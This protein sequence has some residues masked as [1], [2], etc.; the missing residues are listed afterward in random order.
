ELIHAALDTMAAQPV[1]GAG[2]NYAEASAAVVTGRK[3]IQSLEADLVDL[4]EQLENQKAEKLAYMREVVA[5][6]QEAVSQAKAV[7]D[8][9]RADY[10]GI[11]SDYQS[12]IADYNENTGLANQAYQDFLEARLRYQTAQELYDYASGGY[13]LENTDPHTLYQDRLAEYEDARRLLAMMQAMQA[14]TESGDFTENLDAEYL[15]QREELQQ[16][17]EQVSY[18][19]DAESTMR[20]NL[21]QTNQLMNEG[22]AGTLENAREIFKFGRG[23]A[24]F[25][26]APDHE[27]SFEDFTDF[28]AVENS[29]I[30][31]AVEEYFS[32][33]ASQV[34]CKYSRDLVLWLQAVNEGGGIT[35]TLRKFGLAYFYEFCTSKE[36]GKPVVPV[37][38]MNSQAYKALVDDYVHFYR[39]VTIQHPYYGSQT[40]RVPI[41]VREDW[42]RGKAAS[43]YESVTGGSEKNR[44]LYA[45]FKA[46][47]KTDQM[48]SRVLDAVDNELSYILSDY[49][50]DKAHSKQR[51]YSKWYRPFKWDDADRIGDLR[52]SLPSYSTQ[53]KASRSALQ[54]GIGG[55]G[56]SFDQYV[57]KKTYLDLLLGNREGRLAEAENLITLVQSECGRT[58]SE[59][60]QGHI[61]E[62]FG[63]L[64]ETERE[65]NFSALTAINARL[66]AEIG[67]ISS[68]ITDQ[69]EALRNG[70][71][72]L[73]AR[74]TE[75]TN[76]EEKDWDEIAALARQ[77]YVETDFTEEDYHAAELSY[78]RET[79]SYNAS[80]KA[81]VLNAYGR[82]LAGYYQHRLSLAKELQMEK[83]YS[84]AE[85]LHR[86]RAL[87]EEQMGELFAT[88]MR[89]WT[90]GIKR[91]VGMRKRWRDKFE[92]EYEKKSELWQGKYEHLT[93]LKKVWVDK[94][95][96]SA[97]EAGTLAG[98][99]QLGLDADA[100][101]GEA[102]SLL[103]PDISIGTPNLSEITGEVINGQL[104]SGL[105]GRARG[106]SGR[107]G[108]ETVLVAA[109]LPQMRGRR[110]SLRELENFA[111]EVTAEV[112]EHVAV[113]QAYQVRETVERAEERIDERIDDAN[114]NVEYSVNRTLVGAGFRRNGGQ[115][116][117]KAIVD[118]TAWATET[119]TQRL[120]AYRYFEAPAFDYGVDLSGRTITHTDAEVLEKRV[121]KAKENLEAYLA[122]IFGT[123][124]QEGRSEDL[125]E[126]FMAIV[127]RAEAE[128]AAGARAAE[129]RDE[130]SGATYGEIKGLFNIH[131]GYVPAMDEE[132]PEKVS[133]AGYGEMGR[134]YE[135]FFIYEARFARGI[136]I[137]GQPWYNQKLWDDDADND[138]ES[139]G[140]LGAPTPRTVADVGMA[141]TANLVAPGSGVLLSAALTAGMNL[142]DDAL[143][144]ALDVAG[145]MDAGEA[146]GG[147]AKQ[148]VISMGT[149]FTG[150]VFNGFG[151]GAD[152]LSEGIGGMDF[153]QD[154]LI[155]STA[156][157]A[158]ELTGNLA[159]TNAVNAVNF[160]GGLGFDS[161][162][163]YGGFQG[164]AAWSGV[165]AGTAGH[166]VSGGLAKSWNGELDT[167][168]FDV[169]TTLDRSAINSLNRLA[170]GLTESAV[171]YAMTGS[172]TYNVA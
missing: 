119:E 159:Y 163:F 5:P 130:E 172:T 142:A 160:D 19:L 2:N 107:A 143:F 118:S 53:R 157:K 146:W 170:G 36:G 87:W 56:S 73:T 79:A 44:L 129:V 21:A 81:E 113:A 69:V 7:Y 60:E 122:L 101:I 11:L 140:I 124:E 85:D 15:Q 34:E 82:R 169:E 154:S 25:D 100:M 99:R 10:Q 110:E 125:D 8:Q 1:A 94:A 150:G 47:L 149:T 121:E 104:M 61:V 63:G 127:E 51:S 66:N 141:V 131:V 54:E 37:S 102:E 152:F 59:E 153:F 162:A 164:A 24:T 89:E 72:V 55:A 92:R 76:A 50:D 96:D 144:T 31:S 18:L 9:A 65:S 115:Y 117:R 16:L 112:R 132:D 33:D 145:G 41:E 105:I 108:S 95:A 58:L 75:L 26:V 123:E 114:R 91:M 3:E 20:A 106:L 155:A 13:Q 42:L 71:A 111:E 171:E 77:L 88:G 43:S 128:I 49:V 165:A 135:K 83:L 138:G 136:A 28:T 12:L 23:E 80:G 52:K 97:V 6:R 30:E 62:L 39:T 148:C 17:Q 156:L 133:R 48:Q 84:Q 116:E 46:M 139:D 74:Y 4:R 126:R 120:A 158:T 86:R 90:A 93:A 40:I 151:E 67:E 70:R 161:D 167:M 98:A 14:E 38:V 134:I 35:G 78:T 103:I 22:Y 109:M 168:G 147:F 68:Q 64:S 45:F 57:E 166:F 137:S 27:Y 29:D 32:G